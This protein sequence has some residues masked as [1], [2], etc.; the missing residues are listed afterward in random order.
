MEGNGGTYS[1]TISNDIFFIFTL[2]N[3]GLFITKRHL[4]TLYLN[5]RVGLFRIYRELINAEL[6]S[7]MLKNKYLLDVIF[8]T[9]TGTVNQG[10]IGTGNVAK[11]LIPLPPLAE[12]H[13]IVAKVT[14]LMQYCEKLSSKQ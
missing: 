4:N 13:R 1:I 10:N 11:L 7:I 2:L 14:E 9:E 6:L 3:N 12:Q 5:Q 8:G